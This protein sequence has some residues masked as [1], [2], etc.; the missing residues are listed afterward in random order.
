[1]DKTELTDQNLELCRFLKKHGVLDYLGGNVTLSF[2]GDGSEVTVKSE[3]F[4]TERFKR[5]I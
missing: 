3:K 1:M 4:V 2:N 5:R